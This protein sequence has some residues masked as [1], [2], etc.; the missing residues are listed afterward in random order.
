MARLYYVIQN[1]FSPAVGQHPEACAATASEAASPP[2]GR[3][4][5]LPAFP[6]DHAAKAVDWPFSL[7][8][9]DRHSHTNQELEYRRLAASKAGLS[10]T[11]GPNGPN[12]AIG[13]LVA[14]V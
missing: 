14:T 7:R 4:A 10:F 11:V 9:T 13:I 3:A 12:S 2:E 6:G 1:N 8:T 5:C